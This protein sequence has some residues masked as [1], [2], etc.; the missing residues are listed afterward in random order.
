MLAFYRGI[1]ILRCPIDVVMQNHSSTTIDR[2]L[3]DQ[4][5][6]AKPFSKF[7]EGLLD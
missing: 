6:T 2:D 4:A 3:T 5:L 1:D 7:L